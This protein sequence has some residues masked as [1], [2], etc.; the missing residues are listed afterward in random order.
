MLF[1]PLHTTE[2]TGRAAGSFDEV[3]GVAFQQINHRVFM[4]FSYAD[5]VVI[6][7]MYWL[8]YQNLAIEVLYA[9][10]VTHGHRRKT[11]FTAASARIGFDLSL[12]DA[13]RRRIIKRRQHI[14]FGFCYEERTLHDLPAMAGSQL[15]RRIEGH[16]Y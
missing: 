13:E 1:L 6:A 12:I 14:A 7:Q 9:E 4:N 10:R 2:R 3:I 8:A 5:H 15:D 11:F 16:Q